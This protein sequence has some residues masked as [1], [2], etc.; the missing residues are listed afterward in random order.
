MLERR[1]DPRR[2][3]R[4]AAAFDQPDQRVQIHAALVRQLLGQRGAEAG[5]AQPCAAPGDS[6]GCRSTASGLLFASSLSTGSGLSAGSEVHAYLAPASEPFLPGES[7][8]RAQP[9]LRR[10]KG[11][12]ASYLT[13]RVL[14]QELAE[15]NP[16]KLR[17]PVTPRGSDS[18]RQQ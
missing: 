15:G 10:P 3:R 5:L 11:R 2:E 14:A 9:P 12:A 6:I 18:H 7:N 8:S 1:Q 17:P 4:R 13:H 16:P